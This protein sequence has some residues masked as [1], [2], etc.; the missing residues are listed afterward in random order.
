MHEEHHH[1]E[2]GCH[3]GRHPE[4]HRHR[5]E[6]EGD[7]GEGR[8]CECGSHS[9]E[10]ECQCECHGGGHHPEIHFQRRFTTRAEQVAE[11]ER[12]LQDLQSE[13]QAVQERIAEM[14]TV[15]A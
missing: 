8:E 10:S 13:V 1:G 5:H 9:D 6:G 2:C 12:Y 15:K 3:G 4:H 7:R 14:K 11:L